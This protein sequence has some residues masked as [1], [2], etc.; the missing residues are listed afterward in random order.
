MELDDACGS[1]HFDLSTPQTKV[2]Y[3][4]GL[5]MSLGDGVKAVNVWKWLDPKNLLSVLH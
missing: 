1:L 4:D 3:L 5:H 2:G